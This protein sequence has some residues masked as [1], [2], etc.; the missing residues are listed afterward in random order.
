MRSLCTTMK[1]SL[2][3]QHLEKSPRA[4]TRTTAAKNKYK[5]FKKEYCC[6]IL[7]KKS[8]FFCFSH[9]LIAKIFLMNWTW[10]SHFTKD[11][12]DTN[13]TNGI[14]IHTPE[15][16]TV[17][18]LQDDRYGVPNKHFPN[19]NG[20]R[21]QNQLA[22]RPTAL[23]AH[24]WSSTSD[25]RQNQ[26]AKCPIELR[27]QKTSLPGK[28]R[29]TYSVLEL[30][31]LSRCMFP[32]HQGKAYVD[33]Q[34]RAGEK[35]GESP[36]HVVSAA[37]RSVPPKPPLGASEP[38]AAAPHSHPGASSWRLCSG[39]PRE[40]DVARVQQPQVESQKL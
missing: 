25:T 31:S 40:P 24:K 39:K 38:R 8:S 12:K 9:N 34:C 16:R 2:R 28:H 17:T 10:T 32:F 18:I 20:P 33:S 3:S 19:T 23:R 13:H 30:V 36:K 22:K 29:W 26:L 35:Q 1:S 11:N 37:A 27:A 14:Y 7:F 5:I 6:H 21:H 15:D 4:A